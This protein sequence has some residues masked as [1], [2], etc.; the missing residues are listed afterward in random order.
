LR[1]A[2]G[3]YVPVHA[4]RDARLHALAEP[5]HRGAGFTHLTAAGIR[6][7]AL[8]PVPAG[9]PEFA[10]QNARNRPRRSELRIIRTTPEPEI[11]WLRGLPIVSATDTLLALARHLGLLDVIVV[12]DSALHLG[13]VTAAELGAALCA[14]RF[15]VRRLRAAA[16]F[17]DGR[18]ESP[19][20]SL[21]RV[22]HVVCQIA[23]VPQY[24][25]WAD[26]RFVAGA[27]FGSSAIG[28]CT[29]T[30]ERFTATGPSTG[31]TCA[32]TESSRRPTGSGA[33]TRTW[34]CSGAL[35]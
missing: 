13:D 10:A 14:R 11:T 1:V 31:T 9:L 25:V 32:A 8:P 26:G 7:W 3:L 33:A 2:H 30:T 24:E 35:A 28:L 16:G 12:L 6:E 22:L 15:G 19:Y 29:S 34:R 23:V 18:S 27:T 20:E 5:L 17:A 21:L 4:D